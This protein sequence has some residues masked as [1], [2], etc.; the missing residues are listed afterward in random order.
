MARKTAEASGVNDS[1]PD[2]GSI[3]QGEVFDVF[4]QRFRNMVGGQH[5]EGVALVIRAAA[6]WASRMTCEIK[7]IALSFLD[8]DNAL[9]WKT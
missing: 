8:S 3:A 6:L 9:S 2:I 5:S 7:G 1:D 4:R